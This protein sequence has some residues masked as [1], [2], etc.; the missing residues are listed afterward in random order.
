MRQVQTRTRHITNDVEITSIRDRVF[1]RCGCVLMVMNRCW[2]VYKQVLITMGH[3]LNTKKQW[4]FIYTS[5]K[6]LHQ[7]NLVEYLR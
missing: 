7:N 1:G 5:S 6:D 2:H 3:W 4:D